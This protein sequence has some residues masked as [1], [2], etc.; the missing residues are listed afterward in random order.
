MSETVINEQISDSEFSDEELATRKILIHRLAQF[1]TDHASVLQVLN[2]YYEV[3]LIVME[4][5][6]TEELQQEYDYLT[7]EEDEEEYDEEETPVT[8]H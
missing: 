4:D 8:I 2:S 5:L 3:Q 7:S 1:Y 6:S